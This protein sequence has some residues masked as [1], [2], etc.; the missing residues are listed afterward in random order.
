LR[1]FYNELQVACCR[2][3][4]VLNWFV[5]WSLRSVYVVQVVEVRL[6]SNSKNPQSGALGT[7]GATKKLI[8]L[9]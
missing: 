1:W 4:S 7:A 5:A 9:R 8:Q 6:V 3:Q 2:I